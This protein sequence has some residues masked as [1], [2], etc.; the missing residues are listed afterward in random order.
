[1]AES[2]AR[3]EREAGAV[4]LA[5]KLFWQRIGSVDLCGANPDWQVSSG[6]NWDDYTDPLVVFPPSI[7]IE[8]LEEFIADKA[9]R[10]RCKL[11]YAIPIAPDYHHKANVSGGMWYNVSVPAVADDPPLNDEWHRTTFVSYMELALQCG[12]FP[13]LTR[14][15]SHSWPIAELTRNL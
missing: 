10:L 2:I 9:E 4:P 7:A 11:P 3:I 8:E 15:A 14:C 6:A 1:V 13:G 5:L 12:G